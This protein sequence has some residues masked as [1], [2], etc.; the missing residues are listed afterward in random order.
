MRS[1]LF[2]PL[3]F[4]FVC[5]PLLLSA[6]P[7]KPKRGRYVEKYPGGKKK[8]TGRYRKGMRTGTWTSYY[9][10]GTKE[11]VTRYVNDQPHGDYLSYYPDGLLHVSGKYASGQKTGEWQYIAGTDRARRYDSIQ[12]Y[13]ARGKRSGDW[14]SWFPN[15]QLRS[16]A[17]YEQGSLEGTF[18]EF[19]DDGHPAKTIQFHQGKKNG[20]Y[21]EYDR[22]GNPVLFIRFAG[23][24]RHGEYSRWID[25]KLV[26]NSRFADGKLDGRRTEWTPGGDTI[27]V[28]E[29]TDGLRNGIYRRFENGRCIYAAAYKKS[30]LHGQAISYGRSPGEVLLR[31][32]FTDNHRDSSFAFYPGGKRKYECRYNENKRLHGFYGEWGT[33]GKPLVSGNYSNGMRHGDWN[34]FYPGG[35]KK[36]SL[37]FTEGKADGLFQRWYANGRLVLRQQYVNG[38]PKNAAEIFDD[39]GRPFRRGSLMY[40]AIL[41]S[42]PIDETFVGPDSEADLP[43][44]SMRSRQGDQDGSP[45]PIPDLMEAAVEPPEEAYTYVE[46]NSSFPG[47][48]AAMQQFLKTNI[49]YPSM[50]KETGVQGTVYISFTVEKDGSI[51]DIVVVKGVPQGPGLSQEAIRVVKAMPKWI[52][53]KMNGRVVRHKMII[54]IRF[55]LK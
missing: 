34:V 46:I 50:E 26:E 21:R 35:A 51:T 38:K 12:H 22:K 48:E 40:N 47:D 7:G 49:K 19:Y 6:Q 37:H 33:D 41:D 13:D 20:D 14:S 30:A 2:I 23:D 3:V 42:S 24:I 32:W 8:L 15:G 4:V 18:S 29:Y 55:L 28:E 54:P 11:S 25:G 45:E 10:D 43:L 36:S 44:R 27:V 39:K 52:P 16:R 17:S 31:E 53:A 1:F 5:S 9:A